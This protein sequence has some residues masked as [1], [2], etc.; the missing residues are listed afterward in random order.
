[1]V[2]KKSVEQKPQLEV[3]IC[4]TI[5]EADTYDGGDGREMK[6]DSFNFRMKN[7]ALGRFII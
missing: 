6:F 1:M 4:I 3:N 5:F 7:Q 2:V